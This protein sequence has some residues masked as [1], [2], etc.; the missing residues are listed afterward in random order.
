MPQLQQL[1]HS[2]DVESTA[3]LNHVRDEIPDSSSHVH[4]IT[5]QLNKLLANMDY[6]RSLILDLESSSTKHNANLEVVEY[7]NNL[8]KA[9]GLVQD[10][11][12]LV[13]VRK[14]AAAAAASASHKP[15]QT[16]FQ[17]SPQVRQRKPVSTPPEKIKLSR[18]YD[19]SEKLASHQDS[20]DSLLGEVSGFIANIRKNALL[21]SEKLSQ[22]Q[23]IVENAATALGKSS[24]TMSKTG[25][26]LSKYRSTTAIGMWFYIYAAIFI[27]VVAIIGGVV[28]KI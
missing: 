20:Q 14:A 27:A 23:D 2:L 16:N 12:Q 6:V 5:V 15:E 25:G 11:Q 24:E 1:I 28:V 3:L 8:K 7:R 19:L 4:T 26:R 10:I 22:D 17:D 21:L 13:R 18:K 9:N